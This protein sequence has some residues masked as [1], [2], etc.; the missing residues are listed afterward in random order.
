M[1]F[2]TSAARLMFCV[3]KVCLLEVLR[4]AEEVD[5]DIF[6]ARFGAV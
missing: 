4:E 1:F 3:A 6:L 5:E 2:A